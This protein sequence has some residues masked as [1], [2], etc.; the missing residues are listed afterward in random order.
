SLGR[1]EKMSALVRHS[2]RQPPEVWAGSIGDWKQ[3]SNANRD[4][5]PA[6]GEAKSLHWKSDGLKVQGW[7][8]YPRDYDSN[9]RYPMVVSVH[10]GPASSKRPGWPRPHF[11]FSVLSAEGYFVFFPN[12]RG[13]YG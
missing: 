13:S 4:L 9:R 3:V 7:L 11:D 2:F 10:G 8:L 6:W 5:R 1:D 12:P